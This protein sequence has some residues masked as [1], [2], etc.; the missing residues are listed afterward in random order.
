M[1]MVAHFGGGPNWYD[2]YKTQSFLHE[3]VYSTTCTILDTLQTSSRS[4][5][6]GF[7][8][9]KSSDIRSKTNKGNGECRNN[10]NNNNE[11]LP[12]TN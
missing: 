11:G 1:R 2:I 8:G 4:T 12:V 6:F 7:L 9:P 3:K 10:F 5:H